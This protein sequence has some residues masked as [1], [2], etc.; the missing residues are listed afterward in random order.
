[1]SSG[2]VWMTS[3]LGLGVSA[4]LIAGSL[5]LAARAYGPELP[6]HTGDRIYRMIDESGDPITA[7]A[8]PMAVGDQWID[9]DNQPYE[10][11]RLVGDTAV[12]RATGL[13]TLTPGPDS[14]GFE[15]GAAAAAAAV[16]TAAPT[17]EDSSPVRRAGLIDWL[18]RT[19]GRGGGT[20]GGE[21]RVVLLIHSHNAESYV[22]SDGTA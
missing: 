17:A 1:G 16:A 19:L 2:S 18:A 20:G 5:A 10:V 3:F 21:G 13:V 22:P 8:L 14:T 7:S 11:I 12:A 4:A 9:V 15:D 6:E